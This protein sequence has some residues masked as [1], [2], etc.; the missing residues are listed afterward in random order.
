MSHTIA[1][2]ECSDYLT[3]SNGLLYRVD[4]GFAHG[5]LSG[6]RETGIPPNYAPR[7]PKPTYNLTTIRYPLNERAYGK[8]GIH[9]NHGANNPLTSAHP[10][11]L[12]ALHVDGAV[13]FLSDGISIVEL[14]R[15]ATRDDGEVTE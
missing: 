2:A 15:L 14:K 7:T 11:G 5:W 12:H 3:G 9:N 13:T 4:G 6:T 10:G 1:I 8:P